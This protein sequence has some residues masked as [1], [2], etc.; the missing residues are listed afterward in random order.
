MVTYT[1]EQILQ[2]NKIFQSQKTLWDFLD[3]DVIN[4]LVDLFDANSKNSTKNIRKYIE[5]ER[6]LHNLDNTGVSIE[7]EVY[8]ENNNNSSLY[9]NIK[10]NNDFIHLTIHLSVKDLDPKENHPIF[11]IYNFFNNY[12]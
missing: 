9:L 10:K 6:A 11:K 1:K 8:G 12:M 5:D 2:R 4:K 3:M 7:S